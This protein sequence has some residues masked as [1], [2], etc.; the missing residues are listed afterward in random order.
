[1]RQAIVTVLVLLVLGGGGWV[2]KRWYDNSP[3]AHYAAGVTRRSGGDRAGAE[4]E[5][6]AAL[7]Q[8][9][10]DS[11]SLNGMGELSKENKDLAAAEQYF[12]QAVQADPKHVSAISN[13]ATLLDE[14]NRHAEGT[15]YWK[16]ARKL[17]KDPPKLYRIRQRL[18]DQSAGADM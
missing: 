11:P 14:T 18:G 5:F 17:E 10:K 2:A 3:Q 12:R 1:M 16:Q 7:K 8:N 9:P 15:T 13:L 4:R 6:R